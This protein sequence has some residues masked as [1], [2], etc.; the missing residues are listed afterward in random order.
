MVIYLRITTVFL[1]CGVNS[2]GWK[3][4]LCLCM[5][6]IITKGYHAYQLSVIP[7]FMQRKLEVKYAYS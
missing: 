6:T 5:I 2:S 1:I 4:L 3:L 7:N